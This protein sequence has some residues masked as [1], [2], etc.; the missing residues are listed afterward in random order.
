MKNQSL[1]RW[2]LALMLAWPLLM[3]AQGVTFWNF[4]DTEMFPNDT[5]W[6]TTTLHGVTFVTDGSSADRVPIFQSCS[7]RTWTA[8]DGSETLTFTQRLKINGKSSTAYRWLYFTANPGDT[9]EVWGNS[10]SSSSARTLTFKSG[11]YNGVSWGDV[12]LATG[13]NPSYGYVV[14]GGS[15][16]TV[17]AMVSSGSWYTYAIRLKPNPDFGGGD[18]PPTPAKRWF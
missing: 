5:L 10:T 8:A 14:Y 18:T 7:E 9:I 2:L 17:M 15:E 1:L 13:S 16:E 12:D 11:G 6:E 4:S 3:S